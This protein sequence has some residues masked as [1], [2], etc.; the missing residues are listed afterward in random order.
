MKALVKRHF[1]LFFFVL[2][3]VVVAIIYSSSFNSPFFQD[4]KTLLRLSLGKN[5]LIPIANFPYRPI[6]QALFYLVSYKIFGNLVFG[7]HLILFATLVLNN[8]L[9]YKITSSL[10]KNST[11]SV[12][13]TIIYALNLSLFANFYWV[14]TSYFSIGALL[15]FA[16]IYFYLG[17]TL[18]HKVLAAIFMFVA[19]FSNELAL[20]L[21]ILFLAIDLWFNRLSKTL[22]FFIAFSIA[23]FLLRINLS[24]VPTQSDYKMALTLDAFSTV[25]WYG[26]RAFNIPEGLRGTAVWGIAPFFLIF[27][28]EVVFGSLRFLFMERWRFAKVILFSGSWFIVSA[29]PFF[30][31]P[32]HM[33]SYYLTMSLFGPSFLIGHSL[34]KVKYPFL[35]ILCYVAMTVIGLEF[36]RG[37]HWMILKNTGPIGQFK[38]L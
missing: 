17:T 15:F 7:Y 12:L 18:K 13:T 25:R 20:L 34:S 9:V 36:L 14:A 38:S 5:W 2:L 11:I 35:P 31:L 26:I 23:L 8:F 32:N 19:V 27:I 6:S 16:A 10:T 37:S 24:G 29:L 22:V 28:A 3:S 33:S 21:P 1:T 30:F 4:D